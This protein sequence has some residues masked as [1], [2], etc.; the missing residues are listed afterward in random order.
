MEIMD[1]FCDTVLPVVNQLEQV[2]MSSLR[3]E[4]LRDANVMFDLFYL[5]LL[6]MSVQ[7]KNAPFIIKFANAKFLNV[8]LSSKM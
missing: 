3:S 1:E 7:L 6:S 5:R 8:A 4:I 2:W